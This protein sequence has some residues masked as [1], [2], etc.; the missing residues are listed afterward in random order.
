[1]SQSPEDQFPCNMFQL[2]FYFKE[3]IRKYKIVT[4]YIFWLDIEAPD[5]VFYHW[6]DHNGFCP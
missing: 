2:V 6:I 3:N 1:M 4:K 5:N